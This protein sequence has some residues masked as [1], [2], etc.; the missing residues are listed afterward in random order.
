MVHFEQTAGVLTRD[1]VIVD[2]AR[3]VISAAHRGPFVDSR[4]ERKLDGVAAI[5]TSRASGARASHSY[6][7]E[8]RFDG[9]RLRLTGDGLT[10]EEADEVAAKI[11]AFL[12]L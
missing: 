5:E 3:G 10:S 4:E 2:K 7:V 11:T 1:V 12:G 6:S 9:A 8:A